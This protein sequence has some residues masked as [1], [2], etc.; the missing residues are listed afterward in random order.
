VLC[1]L[2]FS[3]RLLNSSLFVPDILHAPLS[4]LAQSVCSTLIQSPSIPTPTRPLAMRGVYP[5]C[6][7]SSPPNILPSLRLCC[8]Q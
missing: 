3:V 2:F 8:M 1:Q 5:R 7:D 6:S 4:T